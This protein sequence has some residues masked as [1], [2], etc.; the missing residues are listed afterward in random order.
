MYG[1]QGSVRG[2]SGIAPYG[3]QGGQGYYSPRKR[4]ER[5]GDTIRR[6]PDQPGQ[7]GRFFRSSAAAHWVVKPS[8]FYASVSFA[9]ARTIPTLPRDSDLG[10]T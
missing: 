9:R 1:G 6:T 10:K 8:A 4:R 7:S 3:G 5:K 2:R